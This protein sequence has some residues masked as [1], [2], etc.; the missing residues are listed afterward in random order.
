MSRKDAVLD[1]PPGYGLMPTQID[2][3]C[4]STPSP[5]RLE[6]GV[7]TVV[8]DTKYESSSFC[9]SCST[10]QDIRDSK[11]KSK[12][13]KGN[14]HRWGWVNLNMPFMPTARFSMGGKRSR[15]PHRKVCLH[16]HTSENRIQIHVHSPTLRVGYSATP[17]RPGCTSLV[18]FDVSNSG[19]QICSKWNVAHLVN[20]P[21]QRKIEA[22]RDLSEVR[23]IQPSTQTPSSLQAY[24]YVSEQRHTL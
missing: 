7:V 24:F 21:D 22:G 13:W 11:V 17:W 10:R 19:F 6:Q 8:H 14:C 15:F 1:Q 20:V 3:Q 12:E 2:L 18:N 5:P 4:L 23:L 9:L 16:G